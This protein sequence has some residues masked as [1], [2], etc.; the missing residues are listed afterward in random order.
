[1]SIDFLPIHHHFRLWQKFSQ[2][3]AFGLGMLGR[4]IHNEPSKQSKHFGE[5]M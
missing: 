1:M 3:L 5:E 2:L 4:I